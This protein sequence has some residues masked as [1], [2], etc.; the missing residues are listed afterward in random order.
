MGVRN[1]VTL[2]WEAP[3]EVMLQRSRRKQPPYFDT[4]WGGLHREG[5]IVG[6]LGATAS[7]IFN[8]V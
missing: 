1:V 3:T 8:P 6:G 7:A 5:I 2:I 4:L